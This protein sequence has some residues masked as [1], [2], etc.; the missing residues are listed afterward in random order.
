MSCVWHDERPSSASGE[1]IVV[2]HKNGVS[3]LHTHFSSLVDQTDPRWTTSNSPRW[4]KTRM[5]SMFR[6]CLHKREPVKP[7]RSMRSTMTPSGTSV[8]IRS[9][10]ADWLAVCVCDTCS[11]SRY[12]ERSARRSLCP[13]VIP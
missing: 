2:K 13:S 12:P 8:L 4:A 11:S 9:T 1:V 5:M 10:H 6:C 3:D 7:H